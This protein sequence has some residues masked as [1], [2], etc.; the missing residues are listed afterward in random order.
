MF[1]R[2]ILAALALPLVACGASEAAC[3]YKP[4][5]FFPDRNDAVVVGVTVEK[6]GH[7][8]HKFQ[9]GKG[10]QFTGVDP[11]PKTAPAHGVVKKVADREFVYEPKA[12]F[13][14]KDAYA[15]RI[16]ATRDDKKGCSTVA[17]DAQVGAVPDT[18]KALPDDCNPGDPDKAIAAC[19][20]IVDDASRPAAARATALKYRGMAWF[21]KGDAARAEADFSK[22]TKVDPKD[23][24]AFTDRGLMRL[25]LGQGDAAMADYNKAIAL[26]PDL[27]AAYVNRA[28]LWRGKGDLDRAL[29]D[30]TKGIDL[31]LT[32]AY[33]L[34]AEIYR[35]KG[36]A[37]KAHA[38]EEA[39]KKAAA[40]GSK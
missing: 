31:G 13:V 37:A 23:A 6:G 24:E 32:G 15:F 27:G 29:A 1:T 28:I 5:E 14:G 7:C 3:L 40:A 11:D 33:R 30:A 8:Q 34:R 36:D 18:A 12:D 17:F 10:Y 9:E 25:Q 2:S 20:P 19:G 39:A 26:K 4:F 22:A 38:D 21:R 16:C 35:A